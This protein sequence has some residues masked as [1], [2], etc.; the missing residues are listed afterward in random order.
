MT[1]SVCY[2]GRGSSRGGNRSNDVGYLQ[3]VQ[4]LL[5]DFA[6]DVELRL[7]A[8]KQMNTQKVGSYCIMQKITSVS[9]TQ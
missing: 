3:I 4:P 6:L 9:T 1:A 7:F 2:I 5:E 8:A